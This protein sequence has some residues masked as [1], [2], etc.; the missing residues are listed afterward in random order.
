MFKPPKQEIF[1]GAIPPLLEQA[2]QGADPNFAGATS[3]N[4]DAATPISSASK[5][6]FRPHFDVHVLDDKRVAL[7]AESGN[8]MLRGKLYVMLVPFLRGRHSPAEIMAA[9]EG[10]A[11]A[12]RVQEALR[13]LLAKSYAAPCLAGIAAERAAYWIELGLDPAAAEQ[14][15]ADAVIAVRPLG[16]RASAGKGAAQR[17]RR[18]LAADG[19][20]LSQDGDATLTIVLV[21][22][23]L[24]PGLETVNRDMLSSGRRWFPFK[25]GG[26]QPWLGPLFAPGEGPCWACLAERIKENRHDELIS[27][28]GAPVVP[29]SRASMPAAGG[30]AL[31]LAAHEVTR[32]AATLD[33]AAAHTLLS[34]DLKR[35]AI[36]RHTVFRL[37]A[38]AACGAQKAGH[39]QAEVPP[40]VL[41]S[42][43][44]RRGADGGTRVQS[45]RE[46]LP[47]L[48]RHVSPIS[49]IVSEI[50]DK[51]LDDGLPVYRALQ[52]N[53]T[54]IGPRLN[55]L[56]GRPGSAAGK[57]MTQ[58]QAKV[59]CIAEALE[60]YA[61]NW[62]GIEPHRR[63]TLAE[64]GEAALHPVSLLGYSERQ[65]E[66]RE[67]WNKA[68]D[69]L[70]WVAA[71]FDP[72]QPI[73]WSP[74]WSLSEGRTRWLP[75]RYC[76]IGYDD[77]S[78][79]E[80]CRADSNGCAAGATLEE[81][82]L[83]GF[84]ELVERDA[85][86]LWW[87]N[88]LRR[89]AL[90]LAS[91]GEPFLARAVQHFAAQGRHLWALD[92]TTDLGIPVV[93]A[94]SSDAQGGRIHIGLG[95]HL[96]LRTAAARAVSEHN[97]LIWIDRERD[98]GDADALGLVGWMKDATI[99]TEPYLLAADV[100]P[101]RAEKNA[102]V[103]NADMKTDIEHC[104]ALLDRHGL[105]LVVQDISR[106]ETGIATARVVV[107]GLRHFWARFA[108]GRLYDVPVRLGWLPR[109]LDESELNPICFFL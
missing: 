87:Y 13:I 66:T 17:L 74:A 30:I 84:F 60:R 81:A 70:N 90:D 103:E 16:T 106:P 47:R 7:L 40:I 15:L 79:D 35:V 53:Q 54:Y 96:D 92:L 36:E 104:I 45:A 77:G 71:R 98:A 50:E 100:P 44:K 80:F 14:L 19:L 58:A 93:V 39:N 61:M 48:E 24:Q 26:V 76:Y 11:P 101:R 89:P 32:F 83:Q 108:P 52:I 91:F 1:P 86:A 82:I 57:G 18:L 75:T 3:T 4:G 34:F 65:Y 2:M 51:S 55:R 42:Q 28:A 5:I 31:A 78:G 72:E 27:P 23:Y 56:M 41:R 8:F 10:K 29:T 97:Q 107:P 6:S 109:K 68:H 105:E 95:C 88:C 25:P 37:P 99:E 38:C 59:S 102:R 62:Q 43:I 73:D 12:D 49:G 22:D 67:A 21:D 9:L 46:A 64:I 63:A 69:D 33:E 20:M 94:L 85:C